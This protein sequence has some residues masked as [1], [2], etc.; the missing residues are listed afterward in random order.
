M[1]DS[2]YVDMLIKGKDRMWEFLHGKGDLHLRQLPESRNLEGINM[3]RY[4]ESM[5]WTVM[6]FEDLC[7]YIDARHPAGTGY[8]VYKYGDR[9]RI[10]I[11]DTTNYLQCIQLLTLPQDVDPEVA[12][13]TYILPGVMW[14]C[15][16]NEWWDDSASP[17]R[18]LLRPYI[19]LESDLRRMMNPPIK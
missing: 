10:F 13:A 2:K 14:F 9:D 3:T 19:D 5:G 15:T 16:K 12:P 17:Y 8:R 18:K 6:R 4:F 7:V 1:L 11:H